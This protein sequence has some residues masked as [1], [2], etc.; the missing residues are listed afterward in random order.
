[1]EGRPGKEKE[2]AQERK[3]K[4]DR[5]PEKERGRVAVSAPCSSHLFARCYE[6]LM[7]RVTGME[8]PAACLVKAAR[9]V[10]SGNELHSKVKLKERGQEKRSQL[11]QLNASHLCVAGTKDVFC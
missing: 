1:M 3:M 6:F 11:K 8:T 4:G 7:Q 2:R 10:E 9:R 5:K